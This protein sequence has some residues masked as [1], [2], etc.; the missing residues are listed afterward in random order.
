[1]YLRSFFKKIIPYHNASIPGLSFIDESLDYYEQVF[2]TKIHR[3]LASSTVDA[4]NRRLFQYPSQDTTLPSNSR[5]YSSEDV[6]NVLRREYGC[7]EAWTARGLNLWDNLGRKLHLKVTKGR[8]PKARMFYPNFD[9]KKARILAALKSSGVRLPRDYG[10]LNCSV[11][12]FP[13][14][15]FLLP[16]R[17]HFPEDYEKI[18]RWFPLIDAQII[19]NEFRVGHQKDAVY[20]RELGSNGNETR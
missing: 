3:F 12:D 17:K 8:I 18:R 7:P 5:L 15:R 11:V 1:M 20:K 9:W 10:I 2:E 19:R 14:A 4:I 13:A 16:I 6:S